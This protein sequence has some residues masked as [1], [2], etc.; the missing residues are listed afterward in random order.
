M[1]PTFHLAL[2]SMV[3]LFHAAEQVSVRDE[4]ATAPQA[5]IALQPVDEHG[6]APAVACEVL[7]QNTATINFIKHETFDKINLL[8]ENGRNDGMI[9]FEQSLR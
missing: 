4:W 6:Q 3:G 8:L 7:R 5:V 1:A 2:T 9:T